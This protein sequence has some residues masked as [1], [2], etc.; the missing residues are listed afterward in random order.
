M[1]RRQGKPHPR[2]HLPREQEFDSPVHLPKQRRAPSCLNDVVYGFSTLHRMVA[3]SATSCT[4]RTARNAQRQDPVPA[5]KL[6]CWEARSTAVPVHVE[7]TGHTPGATLQHRRSLLE[8]HPAHAL[9]H[10]HARV[11]P[12]GS[13]IC[14]ARARSAVDVRYHQLPGT[15]S[16]DTGQVRLAA[17]LLAP[18]CGNG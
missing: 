17:R 14:P 15:M 6:L 9:L 7:T 3:A 16:R 18:R 2:V 12:V 1:A 10:A 4:L 8:R 11:Y 5:V 13:T